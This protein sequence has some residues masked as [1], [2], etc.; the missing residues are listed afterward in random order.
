MC[1]YLGVVIVSNV[2]TCREMIYINKY[3][4][5]ITEVGL[6]N[7]CICIRV[8]VCIDMYLECKYILDRRVYTVIFF[9][10]G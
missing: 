6:C 1:I 9:I 7:M 3:M 5:E 8:L 10:F 2:Y 4:R